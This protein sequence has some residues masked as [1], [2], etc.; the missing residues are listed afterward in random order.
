M[1]QK[2]FLNVKFAKV[3]QLNGLFTYKTQ[4]FLKY[5]NQFPPKGLPILIPPESGIMIDTE[6]EFKTVEMMF[7]QKMMK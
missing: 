3:F 1:K 5:K 2:S 4:E 6:L 7:K